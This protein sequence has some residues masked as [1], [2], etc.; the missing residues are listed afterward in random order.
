L[1]RAF[2]EK[3]VS[4]A[5]GKPLGT[6]SA[7]TIIFGLVFCT[8]FKTY[9]RTMQRDDCRGGREPDTAGHQRKLALWHH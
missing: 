4:C 5:L 8:G 7:T 3:S 2:D 6:G 9:S 1:G